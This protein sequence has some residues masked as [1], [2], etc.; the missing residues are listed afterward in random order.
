MSVRE[1]FKPK[2]RN[3]NAKS[4]HDC[5]NCDFYTPLDASPCLWKLE[6]QIDAGLQH[7]LQ[8]LKLIRHL[9]SRR[10]RKL[11]HYGIKESVSE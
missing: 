10:Q 7:Y 11:S 2:R 4:L 3:V 9:T 8:A 5:V 6:A 1:R